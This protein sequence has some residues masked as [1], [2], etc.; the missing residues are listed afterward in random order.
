MNISMADATDLLHSI[1]GDGVASDAAAAAA[2]ADSVRRRLLGTLQTALQR[3]DGDG[4]TDVLLRAVG[5][6]VDSQ[7]RLDEAS[8]LNQTVRRASPT[9]SAPVAVPGPLPLSVVGAFSG[10]SPTAAGTRS[11]SEA[12][13]AAVLGGGVGGGGANGS[14]EWGRGRGDSPGS[15]LPLSFSSPATTV[16]RGAPQPADVS[17]F[18]LG[19]EPD[20]EAEFRTSRRDGRSTAAALVSSIMGRDAASLAVRSSIGG[21][22]GGAAASDGGVAKPQRGG[23]VLWEDG[24]SSTSTGPPLS[25]GPPPFP[26]DTLS[27][28]PS[29]DSAAERQFMLQWRQ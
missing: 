2:R 13:A 23:S 8:L 16:W 5:A 14:W 9:V 25:T 1:N 6:R 7:R 20:A 26:D 22:S 24:G 27:S 4:V 21:V 19:A 3:G 17:S 28:I 12:A 18:A 11:A 15:P 10:A 29:L